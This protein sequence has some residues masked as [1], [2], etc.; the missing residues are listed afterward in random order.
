[1]LWILTSSYALQ[2]RNKIP[3]F[4]VANGV[5]VISKEA[6]PHL[7]VSWILLLTQHRMVQRNLF[8]GI[9]AKLGTPFTN[10]QSPKMTNK[11]NLI[12]TNEMR[13]R[14]QYSPNPTRIHQAIPHLSG[15]HLP[16]VKTTNG[17]L[18]ASTCSTST[19]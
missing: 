4:A 16:W 3:W 19:S 8:V 11:L 12:T 18:T 7:P 5:E 6:S 15:V 17:L 9:V 14:T 2:R 10:V 1:M 13:R